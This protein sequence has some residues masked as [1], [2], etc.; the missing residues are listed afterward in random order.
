VVISL[1]NVVF[2]SFFF[3]LLL[4]SDENQKEKLQVVYAKHGGF[5]RHDGTETGLQLAYCH[6]KE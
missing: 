5:L 4:K 3:W 1:V 2:F 6:V